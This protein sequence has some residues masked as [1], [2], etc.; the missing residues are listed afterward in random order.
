M[1][2]SSEVVVSARFPFGRYAATPW[3][4]SRREHVANVEWPPSPWRIARALIS[5]AYRLDGE[6]LADE[7]VALVRQLASV[8]PRY[9]LPPVGEVVYAQWMP[10][11]EYDDHPLA[12]DRSENGHT[13]LALD[14][15]REL[16]VRWPGVE[17]STCEEA[18]L[19]RLLDATPFLGQSVAVAQ[20]ELSDSWRPRAGD[21]GAAVPRDVE[22][23]LD[24]EP[25]ERNVIRLLAPEES[26]TLE[27]LSVSTADGLVKAMPVPPGSHWVEYVRLTP[28]RL[29]PRPR[30]P[31]IAAVV[32]RLEGALRPPV[33]GPAHPE[34][35]R[36]GPR[37][38]PTLDAL[39]RK[40]CGFLPAEARIA[41][42]DDDLDGRAERIVVRLDD[43]QPRS[44]IGRLLAPEKRLTG[45]GID[46]A[47]RLENVVWASEGDRPAIAPGGGMRE[48]LIVFRV[49]SE[50][51][52]LITDALVACELFR[53]RLLG[54]AGRTLGA[55]VIPVKLSGKQPDGTAARDDH[56]HVHVLVASGDGREIDLLAVWCPNGLTE[57]EASL[58]RTVTLPML[59]GASIRL[60][61]T[62][63]DARF[64]C[65]ARRFRSHTPFLPVRHPKRR[66]GQMRHTP[67]AQVVDELV[68]RGLPAPSA[69]SPL[70]GPWR[71]FRI[72]RLAKQGAFPHLGAHGFELEFTDPVR[73][74][75]AIGRNSHFG[76]GLFLPVE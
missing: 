33:P 41:A 23:E 58:V 54:V 25:G 73:G 6:A 37:G 26:V 61:P 76:M 47:L 52:P 59:L 21:E 7:T 74:P 11:L 20:L 39:V 15:E 75:I 72:V 27:E 46:C 56:G 13:L 49:E 4:R 24:A 32:H 8:E 71:S 57:V 60:V 35:G 66:N 70:D 12:R 10:Q 62:T 1:S 28:V 44:R 19:E 3:F 64:S 48:R 55:D 29:R 40:A 65:S 45:P 69:V 16:L 42:A 67:E 50:R 63:E 36:P 68:Y 43:P 18:L 38:A 51:R 34:A 53:R 30:E 2:S 17:L 9:V 22:D 31:L 14:P 5:T